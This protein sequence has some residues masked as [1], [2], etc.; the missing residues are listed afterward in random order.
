MTVSSHAIF[1]LKPIKYFYRNTDVGFVNSVKKISSHVILRYADILTL[2]RYSNAFTAC[3]DVVYTGI[4]QN[5]KTL[6]F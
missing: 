3:I 6:K 1:L 2:C 5:N 4:M